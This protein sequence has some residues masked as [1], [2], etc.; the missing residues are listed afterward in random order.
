[1][2]EDAD[3]SQVFIR[4][5]LIKDHLSDISVNNDSV[6]LGLSR[7]FTKRGLYQDADECYYQYIKMVDRGI[8]SGISNL[9]FDKFD[10]LLSSVNWRSFFD[11]FAGISCGYGV[12]PGRTA[13]MS[14]LIITIYS[15]FIILMQRK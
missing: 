5:D 13:L 6:Y 2:L 4:W 15:I 1:M 12:S 3:L 7:N 10:K 8:V 14:I 11:L 9:L